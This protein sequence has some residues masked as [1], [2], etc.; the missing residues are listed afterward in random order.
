MKKGLALVALVALFGA[1]A[2]PA[3]AEKQT[4]FAI[5]GEAR[6]LEIALGTEGVTLGLALTKADSTP[7]ILGVGAGQCTLLGDDADPEN[8]PCSEENT[9]TTRYPGDPGDG[10]PT[11]SGSLPAPLSDVLTLRAPCGSSLSKL[12][13]KGLPISQNTGKILELSAKAP[14]DAQLLQSLLPGGINDETIDDLAGQL[15]DTLSPILGQAPKEVQDALQNILQIVDGAADTEAIKIQLGPSESNI[16]PKG[17]TVTVDSSSA[18]ARIGILGLPTVDAQGLQVGAADPLENGLVIV[19]VGA[20]RSSATFD[21]K[22]TTADSAASAA[23]VTVKVRDV[24]SPEPKYVEVSV[25][26]GQSVTVLQGTP[27]ESTITAA[28]SSTDKGEGR[29]AA[30]ADAV[31]LHLLKGVN[32][33]VRVG[34]G[35]TTAGVSVEADEEPPAQKKSPTPLPVTGGGLPFSGIALIL[36]LGAAGTLVVRRRLA[37]R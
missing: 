19:D 26:P 21:K 15:T 4:D 10:N 17:Q 29:A 18:G 3:G 30:A 12:N 11:C 13:G 27:A 9:V 7:K 24:T 6:A 31:G 28:S 5:T 14:L 33:G 36:L 34:L 37:Q 8:L 35:R 20:S 23:L 1:L 25:A 32:G 2:A 22:T 16:A